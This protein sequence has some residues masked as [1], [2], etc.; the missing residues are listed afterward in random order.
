MHRVG[1]QASQGRS[2][3]RANP[4]FARRAPSPGPAPATVRLAAPGAGKRVGAGREDWLARHAPLVKR[5]AH[6]LHSRLPANVEIDDLVQAGMI[7]L[8]DAIERYAPMESISFETYASQ[9]IRGAMLDE[10]RACDWLP[11][12][13]RKAQRIV[14]AA[15]RAL[16]HRLGRA[17]TIIGSMASYAALALSSTQY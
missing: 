10:L 11:R 3:A 4:G 5:I 7:G 12:S 1:S 16:E 13:E 17:P 8:L 9:R 2:T 6:H 14:Q 15:V